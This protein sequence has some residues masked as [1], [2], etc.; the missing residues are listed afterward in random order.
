VL[1]QILRYVAPQVQKLCLL[2]LHEVFNRS[3]K[4]G[5]VGTHNYLARARVLEKQ[6]LNYLQHT[7][8]LGLS[9]Q[10]KQ[11]SEYLLQRLL[12]AR[13]ALVHWLRQEFNKLVG[14]VQFVS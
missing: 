6:I 12:E 4:T 8:D 9:S 5:V 2:S 1:A 11:V 13:G 7:L 14:L 10:V 3:E